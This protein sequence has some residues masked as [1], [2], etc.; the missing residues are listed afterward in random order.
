VKSGRAHESA[1]VH[2]LRGRENGGVHPCDHARFLYP[3]QF[4]RSGC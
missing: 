2:A 3:F 4:I 1:C